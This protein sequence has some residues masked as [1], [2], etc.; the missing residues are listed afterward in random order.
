M[1]NV[2]TS[3]GAGEAGRGDRGIDQPIA[4]PCGRIG[5]LVDA[6]ET[7]NWQNDHKGAGRIIKDLRRL[8]RGGKALRH[9]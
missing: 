8:A 2:R 4:V 5:I 6:V 3:K 7:G 1:L 9:K